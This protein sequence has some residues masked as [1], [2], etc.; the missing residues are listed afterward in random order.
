MHQSGGQSHKA[1]LPWPPNQTPLNHTLLLPQG[2]NLGVALPAWMFTKDSKA[3]PLM[4]LALVGGG[5]LAPLALV[6]WLMLRDSKYTGPNRILNET[7]PIYAFSK[8]GIKESQV[9]WCTADA[10]APK[11]HARHITSVCLLACVLSCCTQC[12]HSSADDGM[13][14]VGPTR[15]WDMLRCVLPS[16]TAAA[17]CMMR[18]AAAIVRG[19]AALRGRVGHRVLASVSPAAA[20]TVHLP[21]F[22]LSLSHAVCVCVCLLPVW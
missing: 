13:G 6:S 7:I 19:M 11:L 2:L 1:A 22:S 9:G 4:L 18:T 3:A 10:V 20:I 12:G 15:V 8:V 16:H 14:C 21:F 5:I 17:P